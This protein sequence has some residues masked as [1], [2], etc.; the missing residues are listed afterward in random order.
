MGGDVR[1][2]QEYK[3]VNNNTVAILYKYQAFQTTT[4][5]V[6]NPVTHWRPWFYR[7][8]F[9]EVGFG[10]SAEKKK[11]RRSSGVPQN[12]LFRPNFDGRLPGGYW[13]TDSASARET[14]GL[15]ISRTLMHPAILYSC[16]QAA[17]G[18]PCFSFRLAAG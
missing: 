11:K 2:R 6:C 7:L 3:E 18:G 15:Q 8:N 5:T 10:G 9:F 12:V 14:E 13:R 17:P 4:T 16:C 1:S